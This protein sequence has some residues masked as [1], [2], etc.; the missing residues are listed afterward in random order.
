MAK[1][2]NLEHNVPFGSGELRYGGDKII[3]LPN[4]QN[5]TDPVILVFTGSE[6]EAVSIITD[7]NIIA[8]IGP[9]EPFI[10]WGRTFFTFVE[11]WNNKAVVKV[12]EVDNG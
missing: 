8:V 11:V 7:G 1:R 2:Y 6:N 5:P 10:L 12:G 3:L 4:L 9:G